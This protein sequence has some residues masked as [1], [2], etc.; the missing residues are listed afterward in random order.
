MSAAPNT[1]AV[2]PQ[3][4]SSSAV[5]ELPWSF[6][7]CPTET[8][9]V[10]I[11]HMLNLLIQHNDQVVL[12]PDSLTRFHSRA[13]P[14]ITVIDYLQ[15]IV[16]YTNME[17]SL[18]AHS[19]S[20]LVDMSPRSG[21]GASWIIPSNSIMKT[22]TNLHAENPFT[23]LARLHRHHLHKPAHIHSIITHRPSIPHRRRLRGLQSPVRRLLHQQPLRQSRGNQSDRVERAREGISKSNTVEPMCQYPDSLGAFQSDNQELTEW[24][25]KAEL[26][27]RYYTSLIKSH[28]GYT[29][30]AQPTDDPL[31]S[32]SP[33]LPGSAS[34]PVA[35][36]AK[37]E[38]RM[39]VDTESPVAGP[40]NPTHSQP[41]TAVDIPLPP[42]KRGRRREPLNGAHSVPETGNSVSNG[43]DTTATTSSAPGSVTGRMDMDVDVDEQ[44]TPSSG[45]RFASSPASSSIPSSSRSSLRTRN[46][47]MTQLE[48]S[49][50]IAA[51]PRIDTT[52]ATG[53]VGMEVD[54]QAKSQADKSQELALS[55]E[56]SGQV[57]SDGRSGHHGAGG[58]LLKSIV[59]GI[60]RRHD[61]A[62]HSDP[63]QPT[64]TSQTNGST[65]RLVPPHQSPGRRVKSPL[66][67]AYPQGET[68]A[69]AAPVTP[70]VRT[71]EET[72]SEC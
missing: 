16:K 26:L 67:N 57:D 56:T 4:S 28:G 47:S 20:Y 42:N 70:R 69:L 37:D 38:G 29:Q 6:H 63:P 58:K 39:R 27:Q 61:S 60:F 10:L 64:T 30:A 9:V 71:R 21:D 72:T 59:G 3:P 17:V 52:P 34:A 49:T 45:E 36:G 12:T 43:I 50:G 11:S 40:S 33:P 1:A 53:R 31:V 18:Y 54:S 24:Q 62:H 14:G 22:M 48:P 15:R 41:P 23:L 46:V 44:E 66:M 13:A 5:P 19:S 35:D 7:E 25:C 68:P 51:S 8:L 55:E 32:V 2:A 65:N